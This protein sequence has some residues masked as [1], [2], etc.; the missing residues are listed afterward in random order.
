MPALNHHVGYVSVRSAVARVGDVLLWIMEL[1]AFLL[2]QWI[3]RKHT[4]TPP[5]EF[6][7][8]SSTGPV[9]TLRELL[10]LDGQTKLDSLLDMRVSYISAAGTPEL[11]TAIAKLCGVEPEHVQVVTGAEEA[12]LILFFLAAEQRAN[13]VLPSPGFPA[14]AALAHSLGIE[15]RFYGIRAENGFAIDPDE[16]RKLVDSN[17]KLVLVNTPHNPTG[18]VPTNEELEALCDFCAE[19]GVPF[20][21]DEVYHPIY[22]GPAMKTAARLRHATVLGDFSK[23][24]C[25]SGLR[26]GWIIEQDAQRR[27]RYLNARNHFTICSNALGERLAVL[28]LAHSDAIYSRARRVASEN[29]AL[30][31]DLFAK[32]CDVLRW[33]RPRG[34]MTAFPWIEGMSDTRDFCERLLK[35][36]VMIVP[37]DC[38]AMPSHFRLGFAA[39]GQQFPRALEHVA[40]AAAALQHV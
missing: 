20:V 11:R 36:G 7:L 28:A 17:T 9:W 15:A 8:A 14:N 33:H 35:R 22:H 34:G 29:L 32:H 31:D 26:L 5:I 38:F 12:L 30:L 16:I 13:I 10:A 39:A 25:L 19:R 40:E 37:G 21:S 1:A 27:A 18:S 24:L 2:D 3:S 4:S 6:D 23:A